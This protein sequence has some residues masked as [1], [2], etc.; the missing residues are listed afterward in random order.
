MGRDR[1][2]LGGATRLRQIVAHGGVL[3]CFVL[4]AAG[5]VVALSTRNDRLLVGV[6]LVVALFA[7]LLTLRL[8]A[9]EIILASIGLGLI[10]DAFA[11]DRDA[12][13]ALDHIIIGSAAVLSVVGV[14]CRPWL[15]RAASNAASSIARRLQAS[16]LAATVPVADSPASPEAAAVGGGSGI[17]RIATSQLLT[18]F[19]LPLSRLSNRQQEVVALVLQGLSAREI[20]ARLFISERTVETHLANVYERLDIHSRQELILSQDRVGYFRPYGG[21][22]AGQT[23]PGAP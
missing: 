21:I 9:L 13:G 10:I 23:A 22:A 3:T 5:M 1:G 7:V 4:L 8:R 12:A 20:G 6:T 18:G 16:A 11:V 2:R 15:A 14:R 19:A 17:S